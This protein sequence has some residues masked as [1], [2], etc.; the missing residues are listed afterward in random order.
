MVKTSTSSS[1][2]NWALANLLHDT[3]QLDTLTHHFYRRVSPLAL[4]TKG[5]FCLASQL[6]KLPKTISRLQIQDCGIK[7]AGCKIADTGSSARPKTLFH[8]VS[9]HLSG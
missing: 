1:A 8:F 3:G 2:S 9:N 5:E 7:L 4:G 6:Y